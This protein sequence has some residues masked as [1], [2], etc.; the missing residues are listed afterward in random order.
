MQH[1]AAFAS[2]HGVVAV[3]DLG[4]PRALGASRRVAVWRELWERAGAHVEVI[5]LIGE[6]KARVHDVLSVAPKVAQGACVPESIVWSRRSLR[7]RLHALRP[8]VTVFT[9]A[10]SFHPDVSPSP[11]VILDYVDRLSDNYRKRGGIAGSPAKA[12]GYR[13]L[14][15]R[16]AQFEKRP[17]GGVVRT[18]AGWADAQALGASW[19][20]NI[21]DIVPPKERKPDVDLLF[22]GSLA[23]GPNIEGL[24]RLMRV[25][26]RVRAANPSVSML[27]A[28]ATPSPALRRRIDSMGWELAAD[29][30]SL[31][32][33]CSR[34]RAAVAPLALVT[35]IQNKV[36]EAAAYG[37]PQVVDRAVLQGVGPN[38]P[39]LAFTTDDELITGLHRVLTEPDVSRHL[40]EESQ[41]VVAQR[42]SA[43]AWSSWCRFFLDRTR[44]RSSSGTEPPVPA[45]ARLPA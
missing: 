25:W 37:V 10:R 26:P 35:G 2:T 15:A 7:S 6:H 23:Y 14:A 41:R 30:N 3:V 27:V 22:L 33:I 34:P 45:G 36:L 28:G 18:A 12:A 11:T 13:L 31:E 24:E 9:T 4:R 8:D 21:V 44:S 32:E 16:M 43:D 19:V 5:S 29:F 17:L 39:A 42:F 20:P 1:A 38:F 40:A